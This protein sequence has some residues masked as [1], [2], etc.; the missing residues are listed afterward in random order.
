[1]NLA[2]NN[3]HNI[4]RFLSYGLGSESPFRGELRKTASKGDSLSFQ[5]N[6]SIW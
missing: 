1:M 4:D 5:S 2:I 3:R 6:K